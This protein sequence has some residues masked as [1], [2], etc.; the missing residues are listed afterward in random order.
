MRQADITAPDLPF[1]LSVKAIVTDDRGRCLVLRRSK[2]NRTGHA[3]WE[4]PGGKIEPNENFAAALVREVRQECGLDVVPTRLVGAV[5][6]ELP[7]M[8]VVQLI[9]TV[10][11]RGGT[12]ELSDEHDCYEWVPTSEL[13]LP[14]LDCCLMEAKESEERQPWRIVWR[15]WVP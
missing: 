2:R 5:Q 8:R 7:E 4:L 14:C 10:R 15:S 13:G 6:R 3:V 1:G 12:V 11:V 9:M